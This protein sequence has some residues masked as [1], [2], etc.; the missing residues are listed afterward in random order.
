MLSHTYYHY[1]YQVLW[2]CHCGNSGNS[3]CDL[4]CAP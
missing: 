1:H 2:L 4:P 3:G